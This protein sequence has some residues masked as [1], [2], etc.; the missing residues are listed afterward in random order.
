MKLNVTLKLFIY[1]SSID[2]KLKGLFM[3]KKI[4]HL[5]FF[6]LVLI[7]K[8]EYLDSMEQGKEDSKM[9]KILLKSSSSLS[10]DTA[11]IIVQRKNF[12]KK[13]EK[14]VPSLTYF[15]SPCGV[16]RINSV[17]CKKDGED[18][19]YT[20]YSETDHSSWFSPHPEF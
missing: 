3:I 7:T 1:Y 16:S 19:S 10:F 13:S 15:D 17:V 5:I 11:K 14:Q 9:V 18:A 2:N 8:T 12:I 4:S 20:K 6:A